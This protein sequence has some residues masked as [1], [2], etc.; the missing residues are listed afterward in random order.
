MKSFCLRKLKICRLHDCHKAQF[1]CT[2]RCNRQSKILNIM[3]VHV[4]WDN[5]ERT[6]LRH[7]FDGRWTIEDLRMSAVKA[8]DMMRQVSHH[9]DVILDL[10]NGHLLPSGVMSQSNRIL[11]NRP[12]NAGIIVLVGINN[13]IQQLA[14]VFEK[15]YGTFHP[16]FRLHIANSV[17]E[18]H[19]YISNYRRL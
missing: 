3:S 15:T 1:S 8:W 17:E 6:I 14:R 12:D 19:R 16:G 2:M 9:V 13:L 4:D 11:N 10:R 18:A 5:P 7:Q